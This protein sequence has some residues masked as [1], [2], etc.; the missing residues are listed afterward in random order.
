[1][2][3]DAQRQRGDLVTTYLTKVQWRI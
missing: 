1:M 2:D 3:V